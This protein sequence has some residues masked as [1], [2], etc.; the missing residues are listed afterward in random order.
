MAGVIGKRRER[1]AQVL[2]TGPA[3]DDG[4]VLAG[5]VGDRRQAAF[6]G[7]VLVAG[8]ARAIVA[9][10]GQ[11]LRGIDGTAAGQALHEAAVGMLSQRR[12]D[13][14]GQVLHLADERGQDRDQGSVEVPAGLGL[15]LADLAG[16]GRAQAREQVA[17][18]PA[19]AVGVLAEE[20]GEPLFAQP[21][22]AE[23]RGVAGKEGG[24]HRASRRG[25]A[26]AAAPGEK[27]SSS[28]RAADRRGQPAG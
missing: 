22:G 13:G 3:E 18:G 8:E 11:D 21:R 23:G 16:G 7:Q 10:L 28:A 4:A 15:G 24:R 19:A 12:R 9:E 17:H 26:L 2:V 14:G 25:K 6:S 20:L 1:A 5:G 27:R